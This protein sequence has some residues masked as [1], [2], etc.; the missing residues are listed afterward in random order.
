MGLASQKDGQWAGSKR[1]LTH[2]ERPGH[3]CAE[4]LL[5]LGDSK[6]GAFSSKQGGSPFLACLSCKK[7]ESLHSPHLELGT[8]AWNVLEISC[9]GSLDSDR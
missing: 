5:T 3:C 1:P 8:T 9:A 6:D 2:T 4:V 7:T